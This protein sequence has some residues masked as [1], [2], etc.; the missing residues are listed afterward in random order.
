MDVSFTIECRLPNVEIDSI[1]VG[2]AGSVTL[3]LSSG[4]RQAQCCFDANGSDHGSTY[5]AL[6]FLSGIHIE[7]VD[8][9]AL[10]QPFGRTRAA[11][12]PHVARRKRRI[13]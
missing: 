7:K 11:T 6:L 2:E 1:V 13:V 8:Q 12:V 4:G 10:P 3:T 9:E 5:D